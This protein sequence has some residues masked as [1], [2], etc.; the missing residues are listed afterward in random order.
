V[1]N[2]TRPLS[3]KDSYS[4]FDDDS[5][6]ERP[7]HF[8]AC[9][10]PKNLLELKRWGYACPE[11]PRGLATMTGLPED[12]SRHDALG[13]AEADLVEIEIGMLRADVVKHAR[14]CAL[15][16]RIE[17]LG[18][19]GVDVATTC[20]CRECWTVGTVRNLVCEAIVTPMEGDYGNQER[21]PGSAFGWPRSEG[22]FQ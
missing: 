2:N 12:L 14:H 22:G 19:I 3:S 9:C 13:P 1:R 11:G 6:R 7:A 18:G 17:I 16:A 15:N 5:A 4:R 10:R 21:Y 20:S 8:A